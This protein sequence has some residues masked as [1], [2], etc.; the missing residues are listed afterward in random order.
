MHAR[1]HL[2][3][4]ALLMAAIC[5][6]T[7]QAR[8]ALGRRAQRAATTWSPSAAPTAST[9]AAREI[10]LSCK[11]LH[12]NAS[13]LCHNVTSLDAATSLNITSDAVVLAG[14]VVQSYANTIEVAGA[15]PF[16]VV[17]KG[18]HLGARF[19]TKCMISE[20]TSRASLLEYLI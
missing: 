15:G 10:T 5:M 4:L 13:A 11:A 9:T 20:V 12:G 18:V 14:T 17:V 1:S 7:A 16:L 2:V 8:N 19:C 3:R 6:A